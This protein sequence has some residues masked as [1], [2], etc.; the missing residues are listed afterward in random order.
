MGSFA[1]HRSGVRGSGVLWGWAQVLRGLQ[2][3]VC[4]CCKPLLCCWLLPRPSHRLRE[5]GRAGPGSWSLL[6]GILTKA[7]EQGHGHS[8]QAQLC[9]ESTWYPQLQMWQEAQGWGTLGRCTEPAVGLRLPL[10]PQTENPQPSCPCLWVPI[11]W[12]SPQLAGA[13][14]PVPGPAWKEAGWL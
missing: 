11:S 8:N 10:S 6:C 1:E 4:H 9:P 7:T 12:G 2:G 3:G 13:V 14:S 5:A